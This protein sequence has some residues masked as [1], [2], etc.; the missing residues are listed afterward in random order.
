MKKKILSL[1]CSVCLIVSQSDLFAQKIFD[2]HLHGDK[3]PEKQM[4]EL[5]QHQVYRAAISSSWELQENY[6]NLDGLD[7]DYGLMFPCPQGKVPYSLQNCFENGEDWPDIQWVEDLIQQKKINY[8]GEIINQ[9]YGMSPSD[10]L[11]YPYFELA[12]QYG[13]PVGIHTGGAG[14]D[15]GSPLFNMEMGNPRLLENLIHQFPDLKIW[16]MHSGDMEYR[17]CADLMK[18][19]PTLYT[20]ISVI[21]NPEIV[22]TERFSQTIRYFIELGLEDRILFGSDNGPISKII[23]N[24]ESLDFLSPEQKKKIYYE[25]A[26]RFFSTH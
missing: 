3:D 11:L 17:A 22:P 5:T 23:S 7:L 10:T 8:L 15:H 16:I 12:Q 19:H 1:V 6:R 21:S 2:V 25:N 9:Y 13:L 24:I 20:D 18:K 4:E 26:E 14:P